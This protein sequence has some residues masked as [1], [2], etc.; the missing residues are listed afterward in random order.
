MNPNNKG[1]K[2]VLITGCSSGIGLATTV[3]LAQKGFDVIASMR[4]L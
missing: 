2:R 3:L 4:N 1:Q